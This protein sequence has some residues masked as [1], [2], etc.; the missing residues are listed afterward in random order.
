MQWD[1]A[2]RKIVPRGNSVKQINR[3]TELG[4][5]ELDSL[6][7]SLT[8]Q[9]WENRASTTLFI[10]LSK[11]EHGDW[12]QDLITSEITYIQLFNLVAY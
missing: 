9:Q 10:R 1:V 12:T 8:R 4:I 3:E 7:E 6:M 2:N 11:S 5:Q